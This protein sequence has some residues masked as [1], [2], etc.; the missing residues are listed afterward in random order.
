MTQYPSTRKNA[1]NIWRCDK[2]GLAIQDGH[3]NIELID[4]ETGGYPL[5]TSC[6]IIAHHRRCDP[7][8]NRDAYWIRVERARGA[9]VLDWIEHLLDKP[10][11]TSANARAFIRR[12]QD[13]LCTAEGFKVY[14]N[15]GAK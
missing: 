12:Y 3:G 14:E 9:E 6:L 1:A 10:W 7:N 2:C 4:P 11:F 13:G 15:G 8:P 5:G